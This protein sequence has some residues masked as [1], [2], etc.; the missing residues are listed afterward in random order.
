M[1]FIFYLV[2]FS[3]VFLLIQFPSGLIA[4]DFVHHEIKAELEPV[5]NLIRITDEISFPPT[6]LDPDH[7]EI[8]FL[9][10]GNLT[11]TGHTPE[12]QLIKI[13]GEIDS[14]VFGVSGASSI[15]ADIP[16]QHFQ[17]KLPENL[18]PDFKLRLEYQGQIHHPIQQLSEEYARSFSETPGIIDTAGVFLHGASFWLPWFNDHLV[19]FNLEVQ[20]PENWSVVS[21]G[22]RTIHQVVSGRRQVRWESPEPMDEIYLVAGP[23]HEYNQPVGAVSAMAFLRSPD[24][25]LAQQYLETTAQYLQM[26]QQLIGPYPYAKFALV[27]NFWET[28][29]GMPS[30]TLLGPKVIRFP[31]ILHSS[32]PHEL[33]HNWWG[34][35]VFVDYERGNW[36]EG[37][38]VYLADHLIK[39][40][41]GLG[42]EYRRDALQTYTDYV[43]SNRD[44]PLIEFKA[45][46]DATTAAI[47]YNKSM[48]IYHLLR[49]RLGDEKFVQAIQRFYQN[50]KFKRVCFDEVQQTFEAVA[51]EKLDWFFQ[52]WLQRP[53]APQIQLTNVTACEDQQ[54]FALH[55]SLEQS[56]SGEPY[57]L[58]VPVAITLANQTEVLWQRV[59][60][61]RRHQNF[62]VTC[63]ARPLRIDVDAEFDVFRRLDRNEIPPALSQLFGADQVTLILPSV[64][65]DSLLVAYEQLAQHWA[66]SGKVTL[67]RDMALKVLPQDQAVWVFDFKNL[68]AEQ[69]IDS[70]KAYPLRFGPDSLQ[71]D[72]LVFPLENHCFVLTGRNPQNP[73]VTIAWLHISTPAAVAGLGRKLPHYGKY[74]YLGFEGAE[75]KNVLKGQWP[76]LNSPLSQSVAVNQQTKSIVTPGKLPAR[77]ALAELPA[78]FSGEMLFRHVTVLA[79]DS[80]KGRGFGTPELDQAAT[81]IARQF[82]KI[83][84]QPGADDGSYFQSWREIGGEPPVEAVVRNVIGFI[85]GTEPAWADQSVLVCAHYDHLGLGWPDSRSGEK[86]Q[87]YNGAD[88]NASGVAVML[89]LAKAIKQGSQPKRSLVFVAFTA[90]ECGRRGSRYFVKHYQRFPVQKVFGV[91]NLDTVGR[92]NNQKILVLGANSAREWVHIFRGIGFVTGIQHQLVTEELDASDQVSFIEAGIPAVQLFTGPHFDY[93][94]PTDDVEKINVNGLVKVATFTREALLYL[95]ERLEP[96]TT[97]LS[98]ATPATGHPTGQKPTRRA[99]L[100]TMPDFTFEGNGVRIAE[101]RPDSPAARAGLLKQDI[102]KQIDDVPIHKLADLARV[103]SK[104]QP[105]DQVKLL[106][107]RAGKLEEVVV[108]LGE[109]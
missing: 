4:R 95:A 13:P 49:Q 106:Y 74:S 100:G 29:Y 17:F 63:P 56:Q 87:I 98:P 37:L 85:P 93:H 79:S 31:F 57:R 14:T 44:F 36:C 92:L 86:G 89:E 34:N 30:F 78:I 108:E 38:T 22:K 82:K 16:L 15:P 84:L 24:T 8:H 28:G 81:Y 1:R 20:V 2:F 65:A 12:T 25:A 69:I 3:L 58:Q 70:F 7:A 88:D 67:Q 9:L 47:G 40:Q 102:L 43:K 52:Q 46:H 21:Q 26:Y 23:F 83:G 42:T 77:S 61:T 105:G 10:H 109:R 76:T 53:G 99:S 11:I 97:A 101:I 32:Y 18:P 27:E 66:K 48:M 96:L 55:F 45:R 71:V 51:E 41:R 6:L 5:E 91:L 60:L 33:L 94:R 68:F 39:E 73:E 35:S 107:E 90:E 104:Y 80:M 62:T 103:L 64:V 50:N 19:H 72:S 75:P 54:Q 59:E